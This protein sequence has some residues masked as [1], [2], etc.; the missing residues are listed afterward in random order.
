LIIKLDRVTEGGV[1]IALTGGDGTKTTFFNSTQ[2]SK[3]IIGT[4]GF[5]EYSL[6]VPYYIDATK[7]IDAF[8]IMDGQATGTVYFDDITLTNYE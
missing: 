1:A 5:V 8:L 6:D 3:K 4:T 7:R 2:A